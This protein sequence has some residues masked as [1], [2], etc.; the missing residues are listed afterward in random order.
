MP[1]GFRFPYS[2]IDVWLPALVLASGGIYAVMA[3]AVSQRT[4]EIGIRMALGARAGD[5][6]RLVLGRGMRLTLIGVAVGMIALRN[7]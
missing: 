2:D 5:V 7:E 4:N 6:L 3:Y 1:D